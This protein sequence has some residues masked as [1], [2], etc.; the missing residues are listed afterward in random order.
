MGIFLRWKYEA[1]D[2]RGCLLE[3]CR[4]DNESKFTM[5]SIGRKNKYEDLFA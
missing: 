5:A 4:V 3:G 1:L 2:L